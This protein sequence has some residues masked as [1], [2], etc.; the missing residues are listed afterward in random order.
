MQKKQSKKPKEEE[1]EEDF[2]IVE[3][4]LNEDSFEED[5]DSEDD[6]DSEYEEDEDMEC[7]YDEPLDNVDEVLFFAERLSAL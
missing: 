5:L 7:L 4:N 2:S 3:N 6:D 1:A